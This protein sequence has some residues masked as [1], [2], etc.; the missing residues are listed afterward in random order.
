MESNLKIGNNSA[1]GLYVGDNKIMGGGQ[2]ITLNNLYEDSLPVTDYNNND[3]WIFP[4]Q[5]LDA[6]AGEQLLT[7]SQTYDLFVISVFYI[8]Q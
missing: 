2:K 4:D 6:Q 3:Q 8:T 5:H 7:I 1:K